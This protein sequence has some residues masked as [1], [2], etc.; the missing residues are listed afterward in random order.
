MKANDDVKEIRVWADFNGLFSDGQL[1]CLSHR[2]TSVDEE[3]KDVVLCQ[4]ML[5]TAFMEDSDE[6]GNRDYLIAS[7]RVEPP[8]EW[9]QCR[10]SRWV[11]IVDQN[12][13]RHESDLRND[14][15]GSAA[16]S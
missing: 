1:L 3:G 14:Q 16:T 15:I 9:L 2:D 6:N 7:G 12:G 13:V 11:L 4:G 10:G 5:V 8:P